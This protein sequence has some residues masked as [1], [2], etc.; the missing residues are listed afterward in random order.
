MNSEFRVTASPRVDS[1]Q[2]PLKK[3]L[4]D[5]LRELPKAMGQ[6]TKSQTVARLPGLCFVPDPACLPEFHRP[7]TGYILIQSLSVSSKGF[8]GKLIHYR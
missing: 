7:K 8:L 6:G 5:E 2:F 1:L 3:R 4:R